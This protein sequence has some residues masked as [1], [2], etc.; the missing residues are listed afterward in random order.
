MV[1]YIMREL[2]AALCRKSAYIYFVCIFALCIIGNI[3]VVAFRTIYGTNE[4]TYAYNTM[5]YAAWSFIIPYLSC[6]FIAHMV[7]GKEY[8][9]PFIK[10]GVT[11]SLDRTRIYLSKLIASV[12]LAFVFLVI[13][14][15]VLIASTAIFHVGDSTLTKESI[16]V[17]T[18][19]M[20]LAL[21]LF[22]AA[23]SFGV[24]FLFAFED[25]RKAYAGYYI[26]TFLIP[27][28]IILLASDPPGIEVF[29]VIRKY[30]I[31]QCFTL[32]PYPSS[33]DRNV[34]FIVVLGLVYTVASTL[35][36]VV[37]YNKKNIRA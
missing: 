28:G 24:L 18:E 22:L 12:L 15:V 3:A 17:F 35:I 31:S 30:T 21:P 19:K 8:P 20:I 25:K 32:I 10:D 37:I 34:M 7:F 23:V 33:P 6:I 29:K 4:G 26:L 36:G 14:Y 16:R 9:N 11:N 5:E 27:R 13:T 2:D 1:K